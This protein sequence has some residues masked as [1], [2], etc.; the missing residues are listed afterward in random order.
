MMCKVTIHVDYDGFQFIT[1]F[2]HGVYFWVSYS[3]QEN[4]DS[5]MVFVMVNFHVFAV[6]ILH[7]SII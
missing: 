4:S 5:K 1:A 7:L 3:C 2:V 6:E